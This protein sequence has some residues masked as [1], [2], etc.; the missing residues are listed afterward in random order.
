MVM[1]AAEERHC[2]RQWS[3][4]AMHK[5]VMSLSLSLSLSL[6]SLLSAFHKHEGVNLQNINSF[7]KE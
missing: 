2:H 3:S 1:M 5:W 6:Y 7:L 4:V